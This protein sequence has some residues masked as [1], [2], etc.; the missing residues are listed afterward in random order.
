M[1][2]YVKAFGS[3]H[4]TDR[5]TD[6]HHRNYM[7]RRFAGGQKTEQNTDGYGETDEIVQ[8]LQYNNGIKVYM[9]K[10]SL[11]WTRSIGTSSVVTV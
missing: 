1:N 9:E 5:Q 2:F 8:L 6:R 10:R 4:L 3:Y 11:L 7:P